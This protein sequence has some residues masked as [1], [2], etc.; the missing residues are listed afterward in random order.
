MFDSRLTSCVRACRVLIY[1]R[2]RR[3]LSLSLDYAELAARSSLLNCGGK[4]V[5][6]NAT[7]TL[8]ASLACRNAK[9][10]WHMRMYRWG[11]SPICTNT[12]TIS[13]FPSFCL[14]LYVLNI[15][16]VGSESAVH[17]G[18]RERPATW[19]HLQREKCVLQLS[20]CK[21]TV[22]SC[23]KGKQWRLILSVHLITLFTVFLWCVCVLLN[24]GLQDQTS[25][26]VMLKL[27]LL[28]E[29]CGINWKGDVHGRALS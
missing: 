11:K 12:S 10:H 20:G 14:C 22:A 23:L 16:G 18:Q 6:A 25:F 1:S 2:C 7:T 5:V 24:A 26:G 9:P 17:Q 19:M 27:R 3:H 21:V 8:S 13:H 4:C 29:F 28:S 15:T